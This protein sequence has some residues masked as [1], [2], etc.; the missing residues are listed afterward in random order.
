[1]SLFLL[2]FQYYQY[3]LVNTDL[4]QRFYFFDDFVEIEQS[5]VTKN[6]QIGLPFVLHHFFSFFD[7]KILHVSHKIKLSFISLLKLKAKQPSF[8]LC[9]SLFYSIY[10]CIDFFI[11]TNRGMAGLYPSTFVYNH[12]S[13]EFHFLYCLLS[14]VTL[15]DGSMLDNKE[16]SFKFRS[17]DCWKMHFSF[18]F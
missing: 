14:S 13:P 17:A 5:F 18:F 8:I 3:F 15:Q 12:F 1:M 4:E 16:K 9:I 7:L 10:T 2:C 6:R 11:K